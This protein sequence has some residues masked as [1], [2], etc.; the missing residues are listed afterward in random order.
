MIVA[1]T[2]FAGV[3]E[4]WKQRNGPKTGGY[5]SRNEFA[6]SLIADLA[7]NTTQ[8]L[9]SSLLASNWSVQPGP[10]SSASIPLLTKT[11]AVRRRGFTELSVNVELLDPAW[12]SF[13]CFHSSANQDFGGTT[14]RDHRSPPSASN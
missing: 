14:T 11:L 2:V 8:V 1:V 9:T 10:H 13:L 4:E 12:R 7:R 6:I 5:E 3:A